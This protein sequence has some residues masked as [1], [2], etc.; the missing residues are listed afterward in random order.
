MSSQGEKVSDELRRTRLQHVLTSDSMSKLPQPAHACYLHHKT[1]TMVLR[2]AS[3]HHSPHATVTQIHQNRNRHVESPFI[4]R[5]ITHK[6]RLHL[7]T[8]DTILQ[9]ASPHLPSLHIVKQDI[10]SAFIQQVRKSTTIVSINKI[11]IKSPPLL[12]YDL[13]LRT[14]YSLLKRIFITRLR[15][16]FLALALLRYTSVLNI[17]TSP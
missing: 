13:R 15:S 16:G 14:N 3:P 8:S 11:P 5:C 17:F 12:A 6:C 7:K 10:H 4:G 1:P 2:T 9:D